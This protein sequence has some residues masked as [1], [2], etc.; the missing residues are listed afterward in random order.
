MKFLISGCSFSG[1]GNGAHAGW[2]IPLLKLGNVVNLACP[3]AGNLYIADG[4]INHL[5]VNPD[6]D[7]VVVMWSGLQRFD[8]AVDPANTPVNYLEAF[9][10]LRQSENIKYDIYA[11]MTDG[12]GHP[13]FKKQYFMM[14]DEIS[15][16]Y[17]SLMNMIKLQNHLNQL[18]I[19]YFFSSY[20]NY[21]N[22]ENKL[23]DLNFGL[24]RYPELKKY[25]DY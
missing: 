14:Q 13:P 1:R 9:S 24:Y 5:L 16:A 7:Y 4:V 6:Y 20:V 8:I 25:T 22:A 11:A 17:Q 19:P 12:L 18:K 15:L 10:I 3:G 2:S 23:P 21:F